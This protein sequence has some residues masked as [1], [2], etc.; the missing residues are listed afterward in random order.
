[1]YLSLFYKKRNR[2]LFGLSGMY[3][4]DR[5]HAGTKMF[6]EECNKTQEQFK[7]KEREMDHFTFAVVEKETTTNRFKIQH[8]AYSAGIKPLPPDCSFRQLRSCREQ[9]LWAIYT[10][11]DIACTVKKLIQITEGEFNKDVMAPANKT[12]QDLRK[13]GHRGLIY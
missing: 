6:L 10:L 7:S 8:Q 12:I 9:M 13:F 3:V 11:P 4:D 1:M 2:I 5:I